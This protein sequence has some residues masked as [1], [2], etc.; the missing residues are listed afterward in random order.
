MPLRDIIIYIVCIVLAGA[1]LLTAGM[2]LDYINSQR[3][4]MKLTANE[5]LENAPP[6]LAFATV[7]MGAFRGLVVDILWMRAD[8]L[9]DQGQFFDAKQ[10]AE[11]ITTLQPRFAEVWEFHAWNMAYN[12][13]VTIPAY[14]PDQR[15]QWV[16]NGY[17]LLRDK[18][19]PLNPRSMNLYKEL[20]RIFHHKIGAV[21]D[22][23]HEYYKLKLAEAM[24]PLLGPADGQYF[25]VLAEAPE[26][27]KQMMEDPNVVGFVNALKA[28]DGTFTDKRNFVSTYLALRQNPGRFSAETFNVIDTFRSTEALKKFDVFAKA[29]Q[30]RKV[31]KLDAVLM[32]EINKTYGPINLDDPNEHYP[33]DWRH[34]NAHSIYWAVLGLKRAGVEEFS[35]EQTHTDRIVFH[36]LQ[37]LFRNGRI[38]IYKIPPA[39]IKDPESPIHMTGGKRLYLRQDLRMFE[40]YNEV[41]LAQ[42]EKY[43]EL[44]PDTYSSM[45]NGHRNML[46]NAVLSF[47]QAGHVKAARRIFKQ[48]R[49]LYP[50]PEFDVPLVTYVKNRLQEELKGIGLNDANEIVQ[51]MLR[52]SYFRF[53]MRDDD[54]AYAREKWA[55]Q[56]YDKYQSMYDDDTRI[57][58][59]K[60]SIMKY[61]A[62]RDFVGDPRY[63]A[64]LR[65]SLI[66]RIEIE[67]PELAKEF[68]Q[69]ERELL[70]KLQKDY[71]RQQGLPLQ[72]NA[73]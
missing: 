6:S 37:S 70:E 30:L 59:R 45:Q 65:R 43:I 2:Q 36:S 3:Y 9:K 13:S 8:R 51:M 5:P 28:V 44:R 57:D 41:V 22:D 26:T 10:L 4:M 17:E 55:K 62:L 42:M 67:K 14:Q 48:M 31:W 53:A 32:Q 68:E 35:M 52:E 15:W 56:V 61:A 60:F 16:K 73:E 7:A 27:W 63:P 29:H 25:K 58:L 54:I 18:G 11:W 39:D 38:F 1:L 23:A 46:K 50:L 47:Y 33:L 66:K 20:A 71:Q 72:P 69:H 19:I 24:A 34:P 49:E 64:S 40:P 12:I 21:S